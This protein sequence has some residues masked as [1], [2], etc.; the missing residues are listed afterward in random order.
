MTEKRAIVNGWDRR[1]F[2]CRAKGFVREARG[3]GRKRRGGGKVATVESVE[4]GGHR[5]GRGRGRG[6]VES[7]PR[8]TRRGPGG[9]CRGRVP[10]ERAPLPR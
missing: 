3:E 7:H 10:A 8:V 6:T 5:R 9:R 1:G 2:K 4:V